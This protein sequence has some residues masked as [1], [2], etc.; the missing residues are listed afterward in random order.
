MKMSICS[1]LTDSLVV[2]FGFCSHF[3]CAEIF[4]T[5]HFNTI[6]CNHNMFIVL[7]LAD[8]VTVLLN[9]LQFADII[10]VEGNAE[11]LL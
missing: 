4:L 2:G 8:L 3:H 10:T 11:K 9:T 1:P 7:G 5:N 6:I